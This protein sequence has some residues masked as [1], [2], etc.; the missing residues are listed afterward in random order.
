MAEQLGMQELP[1][2]PDRVIT[3]TSHEVGCSGTT[4]TPFVG[5]QPQIAAAWPVIANRIAKLITLALLIFPLLKTRLWR[6]VDD[7][8]ESYPI[9][10]D[11]SRSLFGGFLDFGLFWRVF[12]QFVTPGRL[13]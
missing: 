7:L 6:A 9:G 2:S 13:R 5:G 11:L 10:W 3:T 12:F 8:T 4:N 1:H